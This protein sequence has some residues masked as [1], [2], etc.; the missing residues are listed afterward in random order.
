VSY[1][2]LKARDEEKKLPEGCR[3][4]DPRYA[5][6]SLVVVLLPS[7]KKHLG[8][9][10]RRVKKKEEIGFTRRESAVTKKMTPK[11]LFCDKE[12]D[13]ENRHQMHHLGKMIG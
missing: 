4:G 8:Q 1:E 10:T 5:N 7:Y 12:N 2:D 13:E 9:T 11:P 6:A 3:R